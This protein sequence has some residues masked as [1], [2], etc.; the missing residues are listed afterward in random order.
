MGGQKT[1]YD[2]QPLLGN[3]EHGEPLRKDA[4]WKGVKEGGRTCNDIVFGIL[5]LLMVGGMVAVASVGF[6]KGDPSKLVPTNEWKWVPEE[7]KKQYWFQDQVAHTKQDVDILGGALGLSFLLSFLW[8]GALRY[9]TKA[10][11]YLSLFLGVLAMLGLGVYT[12]VL[13]SHKDNQPLRV[14]SYICF[15]VAVIIVIA[16]FFLRGRIALTSALFNECCHGVQHNPAIFVVTVLVGSVVAAFSVTWVAAFIYLYSIPSDE[17]QLI[18]PEE[19]GSAITYPTFNEKLRNLMFYQIFA[20]FWT[21]SFLS[22]VLQVSIAG[23]MAQWYFSR[24]VHGYKGSTGSPAFNSLGRALSYSFG[25]LALGS[26]ILAI[27]QFI[28][29][30]L[31][32]TKKSNRTN[33][34]VV[35]LIS[36][37]QCFLACFTAIAKW[38]SKFAYIYIAMHGDSFCSSAKNVSQLISRSAFTTV[39]VD[40]LGQFVLF[41]GKLFGTA[42]TTLAAVIALHALDREVSGVTISLVVVISFTIFHIFG[43]VIGVGVDTVLVCYLED[44]ERNKESG[45]YVSPEVHRMLQHRAKQIQH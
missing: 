17:V 16:I 15:G 14:T 35:F 31:E 18:G 9:F 22:A 36:I 20:Y 32:Q 39:V 27:M 29:F 25:S 24:D 4:Q 37:V 11:I 42:L 21:S 12:I 33:R 23:A 13:G 5:F 41:V 3:N 8:I 2:E 45:L 6:S 26:L 44:L 34:V 10:F 30:L 1:N 43:H 19:V 40:A 38:I 7:I 28:N